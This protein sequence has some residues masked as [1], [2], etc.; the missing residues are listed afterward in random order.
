VRRALIDRAVQIAT[1]AILRDDPEEESA[2][3]PGK[4]DGEAENLYKVTWSKAT[5]SKN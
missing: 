3:L 5:W 1:R 4:G 2:G